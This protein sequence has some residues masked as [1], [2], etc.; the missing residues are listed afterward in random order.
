[1]LHLLLQGFVGFALR[2]ITGFQLL[3]LT[4]HFCLQGIK[5]SFVAR[6]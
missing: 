1:M 6:H 5:P 3:L 2:G 4:T